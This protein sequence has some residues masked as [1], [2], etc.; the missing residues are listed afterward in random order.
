MK[1]IFIGGGN[2]AEAIFS[3]LNDSNIIVIQRNLSKLEKL[4]LQ[5][6]Q[7]NFLPKLDFN[8]KSDDLILLAIKPYDAEEA[9]KNIQQYTQ[10]SS[11]ISIVSGINC[12]SLGTWLNNAKI[13]RAMPNT[14][15]TIGLGATAIYFTPTI[16]NK[17]NILDI[18][19]KLGKI[20]QFE[21]EDKIDQMTAMS[22]SSP[23]YIF[24]FIE[25]LIQSAIEQFGLSPELAKDITLQVVKGS[26][27][28]I[29]ANPSISIEQLR[30]NVTSKKGTTE[31]A[32][33]VFENYNL[34]KIIY[35]AQTACYNRAK[36]LARLFAFPAVIDN[37]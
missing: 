28:M 35:D 11:I 22:G 26:L 13:C 8:T 34:N 14:P 17:Q 5:Y 18:F 33:K 36:E 27:G 6:P 20:Y 32:I 7:I 24:Y 1:I 4:K 9:C 21:S 31:Q 25:S 16:N 37:E 30:S 3:K 12:Q 2:M 15:S 19:L 23:A 29:E 10:S